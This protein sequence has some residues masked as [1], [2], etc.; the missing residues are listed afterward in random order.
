[1]VKI[2]I[3]MQMCKCH[4]E[5]LDTIIE[6][7]NNL[8]QDKFDNLYWLIWKLKRK[9]LKSLKKKLTLYVPVL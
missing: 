3:L 8:L 1:M 5:Y 7:L 6:E 2:T 4:V 9:C